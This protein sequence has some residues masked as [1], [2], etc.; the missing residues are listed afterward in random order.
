MLRTFVAIILL[1]SLATN[2]LAAGCELHDAVQATFQHD[3][4]H[5]TKMKDPSDAHHHD[6]NHSSD[7][8]HQCCHSHQHHPAG[9]PAYKQ[10]LH[11]TSLER[12][13]SATIPHFY[14]SEYL[15]E[16]FKPPRHTT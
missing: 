9:I 1:I 5:C 8:S 14:P 12:S 15:Q 7:T 6:G 11:L 16:L 13:F 2:A 4:C 3:E 10:H